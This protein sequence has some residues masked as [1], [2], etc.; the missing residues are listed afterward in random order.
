MAGDSEQTKEDAAPLDEV[1]LAMDV[2]DTLRYRQDMAVRELDGDNR[3]K[4]LIERLR[5]V[6]ANQGI[7]VPERILR[8]GV[9]ALEEDRFVYTPPGPGIGRSLAAFYVSRADWGKWV[10]GL[11]V[12]FVLAIS[13]YFFAYL[14]Y[15]KAQAD[16]ARIELAQTLPAQMQSL[17]DTIFEETKVQTAV[18]MADQLLGRG[19]TA[20]AEGDRDGAET[21]VRKLT[22]LRDKLRYDYT[23]RVVNRPDVKSGFWTFPEA[24]SDA[25]NYYIVVEAIDGDNNALTLPIMNE[26][27]GE[28]ER[29]AL[30]GVRVSEDVYNAIGADKSDDGIIQRNLVGQKRFGFLDVKYAIPVM[31]GTLTRW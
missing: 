20:A 15:Q 30:W 24:N 7:E 13:A 31:G 12:A 17:Y 5:G 2:V 26:E 19:Q 9:A 18:T 16:A 28:I 25:T 22:E 14:P 27:T 3:E 21:A 23:L 10:L 6:Y 29:V 1:M 11:G 8:E 4:R